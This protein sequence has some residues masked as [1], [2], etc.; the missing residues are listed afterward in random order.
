[1]EQ[2]A[3]NPT[4][5]LKI[6]VLECPKGT[7][8]FLMLH[9]GRQAADAACLTVS[10][11]QGQGFFQQEYNHSE[12]E[13]SHVISWVNMDMQRGQLHHEIGVD[14][15]LDE[16]APRA[17][18]WEMYEHLTP[19]EARKKTP[20]GFAKSNWLKR[21]RGHLLQFHRLP[22]ASLPVIYHPVKDCKDKGPKKPRV[23]Q[24][25]GESKPIVTHGKGWDLLQCDSKPPVDIVV[26]NGNLGKLE[27]KVAASE[28]QCEIN[29]VKLDKDKGYKKPRVAQVQAE[30]KLIVAHGKEWESLQCDSKPPV[31]IFVCNSNF[32]KLHRFRLLG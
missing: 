16:N 27:S 10:C 1:M 12:L 3:V 31:D 7:S 21:V 25:Q 6:K 9:E 5:C 15:V 8:T 13:F 11:H 2:L 23:A 29:L 24:V 19:A 28:V 18:S 14:A 17:L 32:G 4:C 30:S 20:K 22:Q 26:C